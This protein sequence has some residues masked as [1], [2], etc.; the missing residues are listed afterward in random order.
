[1]RRL[2]LTDQEQQT[3]AEVLREFVSKLELE[4]LRTDH[5]D[6]RQLLKCR[7]AVLNGLLSRLSQGVVAAP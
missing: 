6:F 5:H 7:Y 3:L 2:E 4:I 1:M